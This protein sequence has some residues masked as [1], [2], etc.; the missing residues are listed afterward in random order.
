MKELED[1]INMREDGYEEGLEQGIGIGREEGIGIGEKR[2]EY[3][4]SIKIAADMKKK[5]FEIGL[6][7]ELTDVPL[8]EIEKL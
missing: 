4:K 5:G 3:N 7:H 8:E 1:E 2:G 6:I